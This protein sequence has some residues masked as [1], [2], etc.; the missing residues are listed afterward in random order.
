MPLNRLGLEMAA[1][2]LEKKRCLWHAE[3]GRCASCKSRRIK[4]D[5]LGQKD[6]EMC[7]KER[8]YPTC[9]FYKERPVPPTKRQGP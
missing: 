3:D 4:H 6:H 5:V 1:S 2:G 9:E 8:D 7:V